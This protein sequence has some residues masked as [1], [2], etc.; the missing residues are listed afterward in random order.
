MYKNSNAKVRTEIEGEIFR[1]KRGVRQGDPISPKLFTCLLEIIFRKL[2]WNRKR[3]GI[4]INGRRL[5]NL[6]FADDIV[7]FA[8]STT[9]LQE[10]MT[11]L[12]TRSK[13]MGLLM[14]QTNTKIITNSTETS[15]IIEGTPIQYCKEYNYLGQTTSIT[16]KR[17][18]KEESVSHGANSGASNSY[19]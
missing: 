11:E 3:V 6:R 19:N 13:E 17:N 4:N 2:N 15:I 8:K 10:M 12:N 7:I 14:N 5:S 1:T 16:R 18:S 9:E